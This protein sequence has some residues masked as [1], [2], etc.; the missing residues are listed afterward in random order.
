MYARLM[1]CNWVGGG[2]QVCE[3]KTLCICMPVPVVKQTAEE[4]QV[5]GT[6][7]DDTFWGKVLKTTPPREAPSCAFA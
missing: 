1:Q 5:Q 6:A 3:E 4:A 7:V 2:V